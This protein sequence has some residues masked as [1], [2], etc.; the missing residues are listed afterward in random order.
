MFNAML[1]WFLLLPA[2]GSVAVWWF[3]GRTREALIGGG[4]FLLAGV[5]VIAVSFGI[6]KGA[7]TYDT[8]IWNGQVTS[9]ERV[10]GSYT[11][12][13]ECNCTE[14]CSGTGASRTCSK[15][16]QTCYE[17]HYTVDWNCHS[18]IGT[19][20]IE[21]ED[22]TSQSVYKL[23]DPPRYTIIARGDPVS[24]ASSYTNYVQAVPSSLF[25][26]SAASLKAQFAPL[27]PAYPDKIYDFYKID[28]FL[29]PGYT[30]PDVKAWNADIN[31]LLKVRGPQKQVNAIVVIAKTNDPNYVY[32]LRDAWEGANKNDVVLVIGSAQWPKIDFVDVISWTKSEL[33]K[34]Q[35]RDDV[36]ALGTIQRQ[37]TMQLLAKH[38]DTSFE[39]R[40]MREFTYLESE[41]DPP[42]WMLIMVAALLVAGAVGTTL[43]IRNQRF[44]P[45]RFT[46]NRRSP[47]RDLR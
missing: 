18:T 9:K 36:L 34:V 33:F 3:A 43:F 24:K 20:T 21:A 16:C 45:R 29:T 31:E 5:L 10:H 37:A 42:T 17:D 19:W 38:I 2:I 40:R 35:L 1:I 8:E 11:R 23:P 32:A 14:T 41:I 47:S 30:S 7:A 46:T 39:R 44:T 26:P 12:S 6:S 13:Y 4:I 25:T 15:T 28:R 27:I 22:S